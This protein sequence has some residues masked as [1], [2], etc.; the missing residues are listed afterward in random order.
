MQSLPTPEQMPLRLSPSQL[1]ALRLEAG[2]TQAELAV[3]NEQQTA[4]PEPATA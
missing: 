1:L 4:Q 3:R 2:I